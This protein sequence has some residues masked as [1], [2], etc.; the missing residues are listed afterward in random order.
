[1]PGLVI[2]SF[3]LAGGIAAE[4]VVPP[5]LAELATAGCTYNVHADGAYSGYVP[6]RADGDVEHREAARD[7]NN[8]P[9]KVAAL[10][11]ALEGAE[12]F[13]IKLGCPFVGAPPDVHLSYLDGGGTLNLAVA[14]EALLE[15]ESDAASVADNAR[16]FLDCVKALARS[17]SP[18]YGVIDFE[19]FAPAFDDLVSNGVPGVA[20]GNYFGRELLS[21][22]SEDQKARIVELSDEAEYVDR[23]GLLFRVGRLE[24][25]GGPS[26]KDKPLNAIFRGLKPAMG[27]ART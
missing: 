12:R 9:A 23:D 14:D 15:E 7:G 19:A 26:P 8:D 10:A 1:M 22:L 17:V 24:F 25:L 5:L 27:S 20:W 18:V 13:S 6:S 11:S 2:A 4:Q 16:R 3:T 21:E